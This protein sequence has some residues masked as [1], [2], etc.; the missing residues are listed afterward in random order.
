MRVKG[1]P[2]HFD[3]FSNTFYS[4]LAWRQSKMLCLQSNTFQARP[5]TPW[6]KP[7]SVQTTRQW[8][9]HSNRNQAHSRLAGPNQRER[10]VRE[11]GCP[12]C[13]KGAWGDPI[14]CRRSP[15][16]SRHLHGDHFRRQKEMCM[17][18]AVYISLLPAGGSASS[19][20]CCLTRTV[21]RT[22]P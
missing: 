20:G 11:L 16:A 21:G 10:T 12:G 6:I 2:H 13:V 4:M 1:A 5:E 9:T 22:N 8:L 15:R 18:I 14:E 7:G 19:I 3:Q 17:P